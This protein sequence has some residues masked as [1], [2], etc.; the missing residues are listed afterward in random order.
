VP[1]QT[2]DTGGLLPTEV[3]DLGPQLEA[4]ASAVYRLLRTAIL[5]GDIPPARVPM[6]RAKP[7]TPCRISY[8]VIRAALKGL[9]REGLV[10]PLPGEQAGTRGKKY[11]AFGED[12]TLPEWAR[13][14]RCRTSYATLKSRIALDWDF[15]LA[16]TT[17][18]RVKNHYY[19]S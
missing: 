8:K 3:A 16:L 9:A 7:S 1:T 2:T 10:N 19:R 15:E 14:E 4:Q 12:K 18:T 6:D 5:I 17:P 11:T 13:D